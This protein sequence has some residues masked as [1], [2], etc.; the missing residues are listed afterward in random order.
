[1]TKILRGIQNDTNTIRC[2]KKEK[3]N[4]M[5]QSTYA[6]SPPKAPAQKAQQGV[7][8]RKCN[9]QSVKQLF[10]TKTLFC[11]NEFQSTKTE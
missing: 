8:V 1:M 7:S 9:R 10:E 11:F 6:N 3:N 2:I 4:F 5:E